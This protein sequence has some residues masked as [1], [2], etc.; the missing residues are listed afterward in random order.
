MKFIPVFLLAIVSIFMISCGSSK[1]TR[2]SQDSSGMMKNISS[3]QMAER[4]TAQMSERL[5][6]T[7]KQNTTV[8]AINLKYAEKLQ[9][10]SQQ[11]RS[12]SKMNAL[13]SMNKDKSA[14][15]KKVLSQE[16]YDGYEEIMDEM[17]NKRK[18]SRG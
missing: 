16:Q 8:K 1:D 2:T 13:K 5:N 14:E 10:I 15:M 11:P 6:L 9:A 17:K 12:T 18:R 4:Q 3:E 7:T